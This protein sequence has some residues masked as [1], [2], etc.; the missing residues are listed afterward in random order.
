MVFD[1]IREYFSGGKSVSGANMETIDD[2]H[3]VDIAEYAAQEK[4][5]GIIFSEEEVDLLKRFAKKIEELYERAKN[6]DSEETKIEPMQIG[7]DGKVV[8]YDGQIMH[9]CSASISTLDG[10]AHCG[11]LASEWFGEIESEAEGR[12]CTF[13]SRRFTT[14]REFINRLVRNYTRPGLSNIVLYFDEKN[15]LMQ[16]LI[17]VDFFEYERQK[18]ESPDGLKD[19]YTSS[20]IELYD[21]IIEP[22]SPSGKHMHDSKYNVSFGWLA[23]PGGI[24]P[25]LVNGI[26]INSKTLETI[27]LKTL[28][29]LYPSATIFDE[30]QTVLSR[31]VSQ[32]EGADKENNPEH[33]HEQ[34]KSKDFG[35]FDWIR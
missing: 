17:D 30:N 13:L 28:R 33:S 2:A 14:D 22:L 32:L 12:F 24:P 10:I 34:W 15:P 29:E 26:C 23:I 16:T 35:A 9:R 25:Q 7:E 6:G 18:A 20:I 27:D 21:T 31:P 4:Y 19:K 5:N 11:V 8:L 3:F 1:E